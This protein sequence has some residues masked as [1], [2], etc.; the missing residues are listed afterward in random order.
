MRAEAQLQEDWAH[1]VAEVAVGEPAV[2]GDFL[3]GDEG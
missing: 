2:L 1:D 3:V